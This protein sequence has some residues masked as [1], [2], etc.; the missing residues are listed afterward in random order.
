LDI[1]AEIRKK[2]VAKFR[3]YFNR[4][5][6]FKLKTNVSFN[7]AITDMYPEI[8]LGSAEHTMGTTGLEDLTCLTSSSA[9]GGT[10]TEYELRSV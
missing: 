10:R 3:D 1:L 6:L 7:V 4:M 2:N 5:L 8:P 9:L